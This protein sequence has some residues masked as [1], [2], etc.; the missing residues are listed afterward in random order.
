MGEGLQVGARN[1]TACA[2]IDKYEEDGIHEGQATRV[3]IKVGSQSV[4]IL[5]APLTKGKCVCHCTTQLT[6]QRRQI[7]EQ[8]IP[9]MWVAVGRSEH[10]VLTC[11]PHVFLLYLYINGNTAHIVLQG[12]KEVSVGIR[13]GARNHRLK[14]SRTVQN[15]VF[16]RVALHQQR[17]GEGHRQVAKTLG[18]TQGHI[19]KAS[20]WAR[21]DASNMT[22]EWK[23]CGMYIKER[24][25][26]DGRINQSSGKNPRTPSWSST[27]ALP[28]ISAC[29][30]LN[31]ILINSS[32]KIV[33][34]C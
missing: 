17:E 23:H 33:A 1:L 13:V 28:C 12:L 7:V 22:N 19:G 21:T 6:M 8:C 9:W 3:F 16:G 27:G 30:F 5:V 15:D 4:R 18:S 2:E 34:S 31:L 25:M 32:K 11:T 20:R 24:K 26:D 14:G 29:Q 10:V